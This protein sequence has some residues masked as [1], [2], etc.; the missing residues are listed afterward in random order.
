MFAS[1][2][3]FSLGTFAPVSELAAL[4]DEAWRRGDLYTAVALTGTSA[5]ARL[6]QGDV[7]GVRRDIDRARGSWPRPRDYSWLDWDL[8]LGEHWQ[9]LYL[10]ESQW[11]L[12]R[13]RQDWMAMEKAQFLTNPMARAPVRAFRAAHALGAAR[14]DTASAPALRAL[15]RSDARLAARIRMPFAAGASQV[16]NA[17]LALDEGRPVQAVTHLRAAIAVFEP[18]GLLTFAMA[19]RRRLGQLLRG[20]EGAALVAQA[21]AALRAMGAVDLE[22][23]TRLFA[24]GIEVA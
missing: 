11:G 23:T 14:L 15:A 7:D 4:I 12:E 1:D 13:L 6:V 20:D 18:A 16:L 17:G 8:L 19:A 2:V 3:S 5:G 22:A 21:D 9:A 10:G 24:M